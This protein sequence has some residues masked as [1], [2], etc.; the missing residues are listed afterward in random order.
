MRGCVARQKRMGASMTEGIGAERSLGRVEGKLDRLIAAQERDAASASRSRERL[1]AGLEEV[2]GEVR[3]LAEDQTAIDGRLTTIE[4][5]LRDRVLP[6]VE[7]VEAMEQ[8][9]VG[10]AW[11]GR[12]GH[13]AV[14]N[15]FWP[16]V[17]AVVAFW[18]RVVAFFSAT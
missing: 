10:A 17:V 11:A 6:A 12:A 9:A 16:A 13:F 5:T 18:D 15:V 8:R 14:R 3:K 1:Y 2:G 7:R 4:T